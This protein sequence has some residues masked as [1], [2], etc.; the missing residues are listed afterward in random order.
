[1]VPL[2][3]CRAPPTRTVVRRHGHPVQVPEAL[4]ASGKDLAKWSAS[5][6]LEALNADRF[7]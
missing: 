6:A 3:G 4:R 2:G 7:E 1:M 5:V